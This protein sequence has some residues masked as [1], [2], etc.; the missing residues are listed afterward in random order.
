[1]KRS[2]RPAVLTIALT[3]LAL[4]FAATATAQSDAARAIYESSANIPTNIPGMHTF[5]APP[6]GFDPLGASDEALATYGFPPRPDKQAD[7]SGYANWVAAMAVAKIRWNGELKPH[8][9]FS[10]RLPELPKSSLAPEAATPAISKGPT[11]INTLCCSGILNS[12]PVTTWSA[13]SI[14]SVNAQYN[15]PVAQQA[16]TALGSPGNIC[17]G[18]AD[19]AA[20]WVG[21]DDY[22]ADGEGLQGGTASFAFCNSGASFTLYYTGFQWV[23]GVYTVGF[24]VNAGDD[25]FVQV[26]SVLGGCNPGYVFLE[27]LTQ[28]VYSTYQLTP[29]SSTLCLVGNS[30]YFLVFRPLGDSGTPTDLYPVANYVNEFAISSS[31]N[32]K[33]TTFYPGS[34]TASTYLYIMTDD[35]GTI[36]ISVPVQEGES[37]IFIYDEN[38]AKVG[39]CVP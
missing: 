34:Q 2:I 33:G 13:R 6:V 24:S 35:S 37:S 36:P 14:D 25:M 21:I 31:K 19:V 23:P 4:G 8:P 12:I 17:D 1:M 18:N 15:V 30:A 3:V 22:E 20:T 29:P 28:Q 10:V 39:G 26:Y 16:F 5:A 11:T 32:G 7:P 27:D 38:C 9:E